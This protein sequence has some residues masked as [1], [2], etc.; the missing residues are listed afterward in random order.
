[1]MR[2][3]VRKA[4]RSSAAAGALA[5]T[6]GLGGCGA[7]PESPPQA[8]TAP[9]AAVVS[10][11]AL[12]PA[13]EP[14]GEAALDAL[15]PDGTYLEPDFAA[16]AA[17]VAG[18]RTKYLAWVDTALEEQPALVELRL[19]RAFQ[20]VRFGDSAGGLADYADLLARKD[21]DPFLR[22][23]VHWYAG[24][25]LFALGRDAAA[26]AHWGEAERAHRGR[27]EWVPYTY[28]LPLWRLGR[29][30]QA[31]AFYAEAVAI[32]PRWAS[33]EGLQRR[34]ARWQDEERALIEEVRR[35]W[36]SAR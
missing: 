31:L 26:L 16:Q 6:L 21:L 14:L 34:T 25:S 8:P 33:A 35:A 22:R 20:R 24:W 2:F 12:A 15:R 4:S 1:M 17:G 32:D 30:D 28:A 27:P 11:S 19:E 3:P 7:A 9:P 10:A 13:L 36:R 29:R 23:R 5:L 18:D